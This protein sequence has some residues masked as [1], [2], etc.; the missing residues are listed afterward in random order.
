MH[1]SKNTRRRGFTLISL[2]VALGVI[3]ITAAVGGPALWKITSEIKLKN[4]AREVVSAMRMVRYRAINES[5]QFGL[6]A[7]PSPGAS[8]LNDFLDDPGLVIIFEGN[9]PAAGLI[10]EI[11]IAGGIY[12]ETSD[13]GAAN[14]TFVIF[15]PDGSAGNSGDIVLRNA[16]NHIITVSLDPASTAR[17][18][19]SK[20][21]EAP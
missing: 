17:M 7:S 14:D 16:S 21:E 19:V 15:S 5:R 18:Q 2:L 3:A 4:A 6:S 10:R 8:V 13:F 1:P 9:N 20:I 12:V 11:P